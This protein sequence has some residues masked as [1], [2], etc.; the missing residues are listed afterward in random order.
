[1]KAMNH[2]LLAIV[3][4]SL[5]LGVLEAFAAPAI[6]WNSVPNRRQN[7]YGSWYIGPQAVG[8]DCVVVKVDVASGPTGSFSAFSWIGSGGG[9]ATVYSGANYAQSP[10]TTGVQIFRAVAEDSSGNATPPIYWIVKTFDS[11]STSLTNSRGLSYTVGFSDLPVKGNGARL[12]PNLDRDD[13]NAELLADVILS[14]ANNGTVGKV[15]EFD[16]VTYLFSL[17]GGQTW[18]L[19]AVANLTL[20]SSSA[21]QATLKWYHSSNSPTAEAHSFLGIDP[22]CVNITVDNLTF[23]TTYTAR[24]ID[25]SH[26]KIFGS[27]VTI[28]NSHFHHAPG[29][30]LVT[31]ADFV[32]G[33]PVIPHDVH[34]D[35]NTIT[36]N[37]ADGIHVQAGTSIYIVGNVVS[38]TGD[39][40][41]AVIN[42]NYYN[43]SQAAYQAMPSDIHILSNYVE[44]SGWRG[45]VL[46]SVK[47]SVVDGNQIN[48]TAQ[49]GLE[50][51]PLAAASTAADFP[52]RIA[53]TDNA[54]WHAG[55]TPAHPNQ[56][57]G[58]SGMY[59]HRAFGVYLDRFNQAIGGVAQPT[60]VCS[61]NGIRYHS[62][63]SVHINAS[64]NISFGNTA[65]IGDAG[66]PLT[67]G[68]S[69]QWADGWYYGAQSM[70][71]YSSTNVVGINY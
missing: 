26:M 27:H 48:Y 7:G 28:Q 59:Y 55:W 33:S 6:H 47:E 37:F 8:T 38:N 66:Q 18:P 62:G 67:L 46:Q 19:M 22:E 36:N 44:Y 57:L 16:P 49:H 41:I 15:I 56:P 35:A 43:S 20:R 34:F 4:L 12:Y 10:A 9:N 17:Y 42:D 53:I 54:I 52:R 40:A 39:D 58:D 2:R 60:V 13:R 61:G 25:G 71:I 30:A 69:Q 11:A 32:N 45:I 65:W 24:Q 5:G 14:L 21:G 68:G 63:D 1:M 29:Y 70:A 23:D 51:S 3:I 50:I 64:Q 31:Q